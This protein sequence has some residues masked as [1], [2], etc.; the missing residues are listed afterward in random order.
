[1]LRFINGRDEIGAHGG[2]KKILVKFVHF[3][4]GAEIHMFVCYSPVSG[5]R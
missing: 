2:K 3:I 1:M 4:F 5:I